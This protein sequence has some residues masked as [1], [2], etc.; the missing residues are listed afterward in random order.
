MT[1]L[2]GNDLSMPTVEYG[3]IG[4]FPPKSNKILP[5]LHEIYMICTF[6]SHYDFWELIPV[7]V[8]NFIMILLLDSL[9][10]IFLCSR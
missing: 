10:M 6:F 3:I 9:E 4:G 5:F 1:I 7:C 8:L 2:A